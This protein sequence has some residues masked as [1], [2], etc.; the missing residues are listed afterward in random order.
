MDKTL[1]KNKITN[2]DIDF[3]ITRI[4]EQNMTKIK[5]HTHMNIHLNPANN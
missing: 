5:A 1:K 2:Y 4:L 3:T